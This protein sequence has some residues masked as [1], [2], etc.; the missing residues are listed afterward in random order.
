MLYGLAALVAGGI[1]T[2]LGLFAK[3][4]VL[5]LAMKKFI[6]F[7]VI[8]AAAFIRNLFSKKSK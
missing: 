2:K 5:L 4:G 7:G 8:A 3:L 6:I 1:A